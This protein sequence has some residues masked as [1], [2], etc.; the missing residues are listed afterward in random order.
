MDQRPKCKTWNDKHFEE[1]TGQK[2]PDT[3]FSK[4]FFGYDTRWTGKKRRSRQIGLHENVLICAP[5]EY[6]QNKEATQRMGE[7]ICK[8]YISYMIAGIQELWKTPKTQQQQNNHILKMDKGFEQ[9]FLQRSST[10]WS[11][12]T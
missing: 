6:Q 10:N 1:N 3:G 2:L 8:S 7:N 12:S 5:K 11:M 9:R 4:D